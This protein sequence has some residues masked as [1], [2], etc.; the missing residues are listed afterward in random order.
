[1]IVSV[2]AAACSLEI[3]GLAGLDTA[4]SGTASLD[5]DYERGKIGAGEI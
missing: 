2:S 1:M 3:I 4:E 5:V